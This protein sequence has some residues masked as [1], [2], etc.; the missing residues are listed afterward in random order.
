MLHAMP[1]ARA[2]LRLLQSA[3]LIRSFGEKFIAKINPATGRFHANFNIAATKTGRFSCNE[4][5]LQ[6]LPARRTPEFRKVIL[7]RDG[8]VLVG[9]D[10]SQVEVRAAAW[11]S[12]D[13]ALAQV[14]EDGRDI[15][16]ETAAAINRISI[17]EIDEDD[18]RRAA[19]KA[20][21]F[22][23]LFGMGPTKLAAY[24]HQ[25]YGVE[26]TIDEARDALDRLFDRFPTLK[27]WRAENAR[28]CENRGYILIPSG[29]IID[30]EWDLRRPKRLDFT[31]CCNAPIQ[32]ACADLLMLAMRFV[33]ERFEE[34]GFDEDEGLIASIH[35][36]LLLE[37]REE[38]GELAGQI[39]A[40]AM[41]D[42]F[43]A[44]F[45]GLPVNG[46]VKAKT[47]RAWSD[48]KVKKEG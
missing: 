45:P 25:S 46:L 1:G 35:D 41:T 29:R 20:I 37:V 3:K 21:V 16:S 43:I 2:V 5:N 48:L 40:K 32:G 34:A 22:G 17:D 31:L 30:V 6:Q 13:A 12:G 28:A 39:L 9:G 24:A 4:P 14:F 27:R 8:Y 23:S 42:A 38:L 18:P 36:E 19:A 11:I 26:M 10:Y 44:T 47:G 33:H 7:A 15:H